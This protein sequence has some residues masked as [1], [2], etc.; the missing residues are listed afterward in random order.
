M[1]EFTNER[2]AFDWAR[3]NVDGRCSVI[4]STKTDRYALELHVNPPPAYI[5]IGYTKTWVWEQF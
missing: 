3:E 4:I 5:G 1:F 2:R